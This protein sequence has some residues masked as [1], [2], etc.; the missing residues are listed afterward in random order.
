MKIIKALR[1]ILLMV[2]LLALIY[3]C[4][5]DEEQN[6]PSSL[7]FIQILDLY[8]YDTGGIYTSGLNKDCSYKFSANINSC[9]GCTYF[10]E[11]GDGTTSSLKEPTHFYSIADT[12]IVKFT[13]TSGSENKFFEKEYKVKEKPTGL[14]VEKIQFNV[15]YPTTE[16]T[17]QNYYFKIYDASNNLIHDYRPYA[18]TTNSSRNGQTEGGVLVSMYDNYYFPTPLPFIS[19]SNEFFKTELL[20]KR[21]P[22]PDSLITTFYD[23]PFKNSCNQHYDLPTTLFGNSFNNKYNIYF[24]GKWVY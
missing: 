8:I 2:V 15:A 6:E 22:E 20:I 23:Y 11:F 19:I 17:M 13:V 10:W 3:S 9:D 16:E 4:K 5:K 14:A 21:S 18:D 12:F 1:Q 7:S 24:S